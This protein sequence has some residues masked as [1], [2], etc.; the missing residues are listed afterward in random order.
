MARCRSTLAVARRSA[1][2]APGRDGESGVLA[3]PYPPRVGEF[4]TPPPP[5]P[6][7]PPLGP[8]APLLERRKLNAKAKFET[9]FSCFLF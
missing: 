5:P 9:S 2:A 8:G 1:A 4:I 7:P 6:P 3:T